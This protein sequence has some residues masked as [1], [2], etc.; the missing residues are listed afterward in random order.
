MHVARFEQSLV[1][2]HAI[3]GLRL[4]FCHSVSERQSS[5]ITRLM[6][7]SLLLEGIAAYFRGRFLDVLDNSHTPTDFLKLPAAF[8]NCQRIGKSSFVTFFDLV[9][10][11]L[12]V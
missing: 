1:L 12:T 6:D 10:C 11:K 2:S 3:T 8:L 5:V 9:E 7:H 4:G